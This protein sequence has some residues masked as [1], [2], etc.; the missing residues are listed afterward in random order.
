MM[1]NG[2]SKS[3]STIENKTSSRLPALQVA[4]FGHKAC[5]YGLD[6]R[7]NDTGYVTKAAGQISATWLM[8]F[9]SNWAKWPGARIQAVVEVPYSRADSGSLFDPEIEPSR[10]LVFEM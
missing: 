9:G 7:R 10:A 5:W 2:L 4:G 8:I 3:C 1:P 6:V